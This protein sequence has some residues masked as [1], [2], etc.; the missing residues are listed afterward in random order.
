MWFALIH[1]ITS[2]VL[3][4]APQALSIELGIEQAGVAQA[5]KEL[6]I[7]PSS[8]WQELKND[9]HLIVLSR[10]PNPHP[11]E[12]FSL[13]LLILDSARPGKIIAQPTIQLRES[14]QTRARLKLDNGD[15]VS[16]RVKKEPN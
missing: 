10:T 9:S 11:G 14:E 13:E 6:L 16:I 7:S 3:F 12:Q 5:K 15:W 2:Q 4:A 8:D 1:I